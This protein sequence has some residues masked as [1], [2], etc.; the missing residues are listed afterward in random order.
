MRLIFYRIFVA[1][2]ALACNSRV[3]PPFVQCARATRFAFYCATPVVAAATAATH[4]H[5][6]SATAFAGTGCFSCCFPYFVFA[7]STRWFILLLLL[8]LPPLRHTAAHNHARAASTT[9]AVGAFSCCYTK[10][11]LP[12][13]QGGLSWCSC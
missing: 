6:I 1:R 12:V 7:R 5:G 3:L 9:V 11:I 13:S 10:F 4:N 2:I 8:L